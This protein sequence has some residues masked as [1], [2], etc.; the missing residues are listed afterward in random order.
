MLGSARGAGRAPTAKARPYRDKTPGVRRPTGV[1]ARHGRRDRRR[2]ARTAQTRPLLGLV[3]RARG[4]TLRAATRT[5]AVGAADMR[6]RVSVQ[7]RG[8]NGFAATVG[9]AS[10]QHSRGRGARAATGFLLVALGAIAPARGDC[11]G[12]GEPSP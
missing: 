5:L 8:G 2:P 12:P 4:S 10:R 6:L 7:S 3:V 1:K 11:G 9:R